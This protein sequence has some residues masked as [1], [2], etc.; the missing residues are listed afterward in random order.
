MVSCGELPLLPDTLPQMDV[1]SALHEVLAVKI[2]GDEA[3]RLCT[4]K[5]QSLVRWINE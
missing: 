2:R 3:F 4:E 5:H 1:E